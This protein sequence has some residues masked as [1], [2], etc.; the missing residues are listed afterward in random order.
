[1]GVALGSTDTCVTKEG[2]NVTDVRAAFKEMGGKGV[3]KAVD[4][5]AL[6]DVGT[7]DGFFENLL[8]GTD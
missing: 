4:G 2:L 8:G 1:M 5:N 7:A 3:T 6:L